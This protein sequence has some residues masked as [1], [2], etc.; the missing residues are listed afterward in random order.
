TLAKL[1]SPDCWIVLD[2]VQFARRD[3]QHPT[4][5]WTCSN[6]RHVAGPDT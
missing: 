4:A 3:Y 5:F 1:F 6:W 2:D